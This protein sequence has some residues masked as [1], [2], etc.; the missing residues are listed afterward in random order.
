MKQTRPRSDSFE[1]AAASGIVPPGRLTTADQIEPLLR[2]VDLERILACSRRT[3]ERLKITGRL[4]KPDMSVG[5]SPRWKR[6]TI[7]AWISKG[8]R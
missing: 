4:P 7:E 2:M 6:T 1:M 8:G 5:R 3:L